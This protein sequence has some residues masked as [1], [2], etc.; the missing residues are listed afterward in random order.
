MPLYGITIPA[1]H[2]IFQILLPNDQIIM[3]GCYIRFKILKDSTKHD[4]GHNFNEFPNMENI[5]K[6]H[7]LFQRI[8]TGFFI[9]LTHFN[10]SGL[11]SF[12]VI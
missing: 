4:I 5:E 3:H 9:L 6:N 11:F 7:T 10:I 12:L 2:V 8:F 1:S